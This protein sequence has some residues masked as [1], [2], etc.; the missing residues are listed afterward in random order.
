[1]NLHELTERQIRAIE[2][3]RAVDAM[4]G[5][6]IAWEPVIEWHIMTP[7]GGSM[8]GGTIF[9]EKAPRG[10]VAEEFERNREHYERHGAKVKAVEVYPLFTRSYG[11]AFALI[12]KMC[13]PEAGPGLKMVGFQLGVGAGTGLRQDPD[14][15][16]YRN[17]AGEWCNVDGFTNYDATARFF[18]AN[19][20]MFDRRAGASNGRCGDEI[21]VPLAICRAALLVLR[22]HG[23]VFDA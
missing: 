18:S 12:E 7:D 13:K 11:A 19:I 22:F 8:F 20:V 21:A 6:A 4:I 10:M 9:G 2:A 14:K 23:E 5:Q 15:P 17:A 3:S 16:A 1:M